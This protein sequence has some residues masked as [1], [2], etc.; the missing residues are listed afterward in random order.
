MSAWC[1]HAAACADEYKPA[2]MVRVKRDI[3]W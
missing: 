3:W 1:E 2:V